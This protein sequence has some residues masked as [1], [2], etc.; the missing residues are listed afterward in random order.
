MHTGTLSQ[1]K[2]IEYWWSFYFRTRGSWWR[3]LF[4]QLE[5]NGTLD[6]SS[7]TDIECLWYCFFKNTSTRFVHS[8]K[9]M[10]LPQNT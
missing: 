2:S 8:K 5:A 6:T 1:N 3:D 9:P 4:R 7:E 10:E